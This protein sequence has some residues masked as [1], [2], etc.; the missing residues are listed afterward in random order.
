[1][2]TNQ[3]VFFFFPEVHRSI[4][5]P[6]ELFTDAKAKGAIS[7]FQKK[8]TTISYQINE[9]NKKLEEPYRYTYLLPKNVPNSI[10]I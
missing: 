5:Y 10:A 7:E 1:M 9:R 6:E 4:Q 8:L 2:M 3:N